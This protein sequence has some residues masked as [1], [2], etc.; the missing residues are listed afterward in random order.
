[1]EL[2]WQLQSKYFLQPYKDYQAWLM[3]EMMKHYYPYMMTQGFMSGPAIHRFF[4]I[5]KGKK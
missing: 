3:S 5:N 2:M 4:L 1:M